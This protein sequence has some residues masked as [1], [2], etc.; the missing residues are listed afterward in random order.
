MQ[1]VLRTVKIGLFWVLMKGK[2]PQ[3]KSDTFFQYGK[4]HGY[5]PYLW[6]NNSKTC[7][8]PKP[9]NVEKE[10]AQKRNSVSRSFPKLFFP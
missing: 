6:R 3:P 8:S 10:H 5:K 1:K 2:S 4:H 7:Y 9:T